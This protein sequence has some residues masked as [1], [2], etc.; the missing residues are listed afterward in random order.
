MLK[1]LLAAIHLERTQLFMYCVTLRS[2]SQLKPTAEII[3][4]YTNTLKFMSEA[5]F[6]EFIKSKK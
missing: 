5:H 3:L 1:H 4:F 2:Y 6:N